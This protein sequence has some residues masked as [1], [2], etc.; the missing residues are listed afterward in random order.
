MVNEM[1]RE[2]HKSQVHPPVARSVRVFRKI[3][4]SSIFLVLV[5]SL[6]TFIVGSLSYAS[7]E[8]PGWFV[9]SSSLVGVGSF[10]FLAKSSY[11]D[12]NFAKNRERPLPLRWWIL[13]VVVLL[14]SFFGLSVYMLYVVG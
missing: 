5:T 9:L 1:S 3:G 11:L 13:P 10:A 4:A 12:E 14:V 7:R 8:I 6:V 2:H